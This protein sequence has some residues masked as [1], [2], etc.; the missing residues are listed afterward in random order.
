MTNEIGI[1][2]LSSIWVSQIFF[3]FSAL[4][5]FIENVKIQV[6]VLEF[7]QNQFVE[8]HATKL[9]QNAY[10][11]L[12]F[13]VDMWTIKILREV[14]FYPHATSRAKNLI[15][16]LTRNFL[17]QKTSQHVVSPSIW[18]ACCTWKAWKKRSCFEYHGKSM[19]RQI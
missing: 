7:V 2:L 14:S 4:K 12:L 15:M 13:W 3:Q 5:N 8:L 19:P 6:S 10:L 18:F 17:Q 11:T 16:K 1:L 9:L